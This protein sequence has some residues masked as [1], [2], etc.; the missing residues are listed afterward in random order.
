MPISTEVSAPPSIS[1]PVL[2]Y[3]RQTG[4]I[5]AE[6][7]VG[8]RFM[9]LSVGTR[10]GRRLTQGMLTRPII[11][12]LYGWWQKH[13]ASRGQ[14]PGFIR[15]FGIDMDEVEIPPGG[16]R[17]FNDFFIR[18]LKPQA[19]PLGKDP[20][21]LISPADGRIQCFPLEKDTRLDIKGSTLRLKEIIGDE[22]TCAAYIGG[23]GLQV[24]LAPVDYH[25]FAYIDD[26]TQE[27][28][29]KLDGPLYSVNPVALRVWPRVWAQNYRHWCRLITTAFGPVL[30]V[31]VG[32]MLVGSIVQHRPQGGPCRR[33]EEK[34]YFA[35]GGSTVLL[36]FAPN[37]VEMDADIRKYSRQGIETLV[38]YGGAIGRTR[39]TA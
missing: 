27:P 20:G 19:R 23:I 26:G 35:L 29:H 13:P 39:K 11:S 14:I 38:Q 28:V 9:D 17:S 4:R 10:A 16:F 12:R 21:V 6:T 3:N 32:A 22:A 18:R 37:T 33:G 2:L 8:R 34:G 5:E 15:Q 30:Q 7:I 36:F 1:A 31:E 25:R 24:R